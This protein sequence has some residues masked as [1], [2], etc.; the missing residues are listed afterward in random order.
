MTNKELDIMKKME[1]MN[2]YLKIIGKWPKKNL[3]MSAKN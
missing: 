2:M 3:E 1:Y